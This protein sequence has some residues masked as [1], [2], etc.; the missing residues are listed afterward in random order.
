MLLEAFP[1]DLFPAYRARDPIERV[2]ALLEPLTVPAFSREADLVA[3]EHA[4]T[5]VENAVEDQIRYFT[6]D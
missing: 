3:D 5:L 1:G 6:H 2:P 4:E